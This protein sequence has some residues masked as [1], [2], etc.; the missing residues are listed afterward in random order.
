[1][2]GSKPG[3]KAGFDLSLMMKML[4]VVTILLCVFMFILQ[5]HQSYAAYSDFD[6]VQTLSNVRPDK[7]SFPMLVLCD[8][9]S[10]FKV[11]GGGPGPG[12]GGD[13]GGSTQSSDQEDSST[14]S[15]PNSDPD[16]LQSF[17]QGLD[18]AAG[19]PPQ[20]QTKFKGWTENPKENVLNMSTMANIT[21][22]KI[23][24]YLK[25]HLMKDSEHKDS[26]L[27]RQL[28][29]KPLRVNYEW[30]MCYTAELGD[31]MTE[32]YGQEEE[33]AVI[34]YVE[35]SAKKTLQI[36]L[37]DRNDDNGYIFRGFNAALNRPQLRRY[38]FVVF[39]ISL[40]QT[41][42]NIENPRTG[43][44]DY[45]NKTVTENAEEAAM[46]NFAFLGCLPPWFTDKEELMCKPS[47]PNI[48]E[49][50]AKYKETFIFNLIGRFNTLIYFLLSWI[51]RALLQPPQGAVH[52][53]LHDCGYPGADCDYHYIYRTGETRG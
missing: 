38:N 45:K 37:T 9:D 29:L 2:M 39:S 28:E 21:E 23:K 10:P 26:D 36:K 19:L 13:G 24:V 7:I 30:G 47:T 52:P 8:H 17:K 20:N 15:D 34:L 16:P 43:C 5:V 31:A 44:R 6:F 4:E 12:P 42:L 48:T 51:P 3:M 1:M 50:Y 25:K 40:T 35:Y 22:Y 11:G 46:E 41:E 14:D 32:L 33:N 53:S 18:F 27:S 49:N